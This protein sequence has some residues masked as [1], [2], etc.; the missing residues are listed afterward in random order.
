MSHNHGS[1]PK[2]LLNNVKK[3]IKSHGM[4]MRYR[5]Q[6][7]MHNDTKNM[8]APQDIAALDNTPPKPPKHDSESSTKYSEDPNP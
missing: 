5:N 6:T 8:P 7:I 2:S 1:H 3:D 4:A